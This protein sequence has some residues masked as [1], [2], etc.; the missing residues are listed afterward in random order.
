MALLHHGYR[1]LRDDR[2]LQAVKDRGQR[3]VGVANVTDFLRPHQTG[4]LEVVAVPSN[5]AARKR[6]WQVEIRRPKDHQL[7]TRGQVRVQ[8][9]EATT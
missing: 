3:A 9:I 7:V 8:N 2:R 5:R 4:R 6:L 1:D